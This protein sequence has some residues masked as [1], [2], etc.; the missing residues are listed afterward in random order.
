[1]KSCIFFIIMY[2]LYKFTRTKTCQTLY[3]CHSNTWYSRIIARYECCHRSIIVLSTPYAV[4]ALEAVLMLFSFHIFN[5]WYFFLST[6]FMLF[7]S[8]TNSVLIETDGTA[9]RCFFFCFCFISKQRENKQ[10]KLMAYSI[11]QPVLSI[12]RRKSEGRKLYLCR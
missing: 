3:E 8:T 11:V 5:M 7:T 4:H 2:T 6:K 9:C 12:K 10:L 1:M